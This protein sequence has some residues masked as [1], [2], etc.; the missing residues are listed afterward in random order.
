M[1]WGTMTQTFHYHKQNL[2]KK[3][4]PITINL[5]FDQIV[6][7]LLCIE[8]RSSD[9]LTV[10]DNG[11]GGWNLKWRVPGKPIP[12]VYKK[13]LVYHSLIEGLSLRRMTTSPPTS[14]GRTTRAPR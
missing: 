11:A 6:E 14:R 1:N 5:S 4:W 7:S 2:P 8:D 10:V 3:T 9:H 12:Y 13:N